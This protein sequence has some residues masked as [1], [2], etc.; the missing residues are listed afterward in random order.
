MRNILFMLD[1]ALLSISPVGCGQLVKMLITL[2]PHGIFASFAFLFILTLSSHLYAKRC[3]G[4]WE[5]LKRRK[6]P[7]ITKSRLNKKKMKIE[8]IIKKEEA[9]YS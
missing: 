7:K 1:E 6:L 2:E 8:I 3:R 9:I 4:S 5:D